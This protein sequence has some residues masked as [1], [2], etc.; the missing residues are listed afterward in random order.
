M[1]LR[2][3]TTLGKEMATLTRLG[4]D[5]WERHLRKWRKSGQTQSQY[6]VSAGLNIKT[7][8]RWKLLLA[9]PLTGKVPV[10][11]T[12]EKPMSLVPVRLAQPEVVDTRIGCIRDIRIRLDDR[13]WVVDVPFG[14]DPKH[15]AN[16][17]KAVAGVTQ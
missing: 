6:C 10:P 5:Y 16:V 8:S 11:P 13:Q 9:A 3:S 14:V 17:L 4:K 15:L 1:K 7:F 2:A 12:I